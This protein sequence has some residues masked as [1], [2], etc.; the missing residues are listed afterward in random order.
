MNRMILGAAGLLLSTSALAGV[1]VA[2]SDDAKL[3]PAASPVAVEGRPTGL[4][5][6]MIH[7]AMLIDWTAKNA[8]AAEPASLEIKA[9]DEPKLIRPQPASRAGAEAPATMA[10][11]ADAEIEQDESALTAPL[12]ARLMT[13]SAGRSRP[14]MPARRRSTCRRDPRLRTIR[15]ARRGRATTIASSSTSR[16]SRRPRQ[17]AGGD[18]RARQRP[19][20]H[21]R[22]RGAGRDDEAERDSQVRP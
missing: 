6:S 10:I 22:S 16:A 15:P 18:R 7:N 20:R 17:L 12:A 5:R 1:S 21:G 19:D 8:V 4:D 14:P 2:K 11:E 13:A 3:A 9:M